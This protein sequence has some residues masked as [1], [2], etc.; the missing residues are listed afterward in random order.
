MD[1]IGLFKKTKN[2]VLIFIVLICELDSRMK[3][4]YL[5]RK[6]QNDEKINNPLEGIIIL[7][8]PVGKLLFG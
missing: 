4:N 5:S 3:R 2:G 1:C 7:V 6:D 8:D